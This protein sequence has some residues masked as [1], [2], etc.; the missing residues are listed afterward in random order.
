VG[1]PKYDLGQLV[2]DEEAQIDPESLCRTMGKA[3]LRQYALQ[4]I[5]ARDVSDAHIEGRIHL[6][7]LEEPLK[8]HGLSPSVASLRRTG[9]RVRGSAVLSEPARDA[10]TF[11][12]Q[13]GRVI[14]DARRYVSGPVTLH[15][16]S[17]VYDQ[18]LWGT[19]EESVRTEVEHLSVVIDGATAGGHPRHRTAPRIASC[20]RA[21]L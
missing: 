10:R 21:L 1:L 15:N 19:D 2:G 5:F 16:L 17:E 4:E 11:T 12:A 18:L 3:T 6:H 13:L 20:A 7:G 8:L 9:V 14:A